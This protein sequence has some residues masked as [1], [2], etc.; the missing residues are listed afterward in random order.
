MTDR[1]SI[2]DIINYKGK[3][4]DNDTI[5]EEGEGLSMAEQMFAPGMIV[6]DLEEE[7]KERV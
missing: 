6:A 5:K 1:P 2:D 3:A 4:D 7:I